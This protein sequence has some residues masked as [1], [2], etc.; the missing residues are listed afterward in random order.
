M[1]SKGKTGTGTKNNKTET[2]AVEITEAIALSIASS[3]GSTPGPV[4]SR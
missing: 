2:D 3:P 1:A 4:R